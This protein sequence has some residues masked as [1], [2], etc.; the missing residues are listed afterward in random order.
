MAKITSGSK[1]KLAPNLAGLGV[2][3]TEAGSTGG[4][5]WV[6]TSTFQITIAE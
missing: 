1:L 6:D 2:T 5:I 3:D 4:S